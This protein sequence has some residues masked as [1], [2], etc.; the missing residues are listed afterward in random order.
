MMMG[1]QPELRKPTTDRLGQGELASGQASRAFHLLSRWAATPIPRATCGAIC[2]CAMAAGFIALFATAALAADADLIRHGEYLATAGDCVACHTA[3]GGKAHAGGLA[4]QTPIGEIYASNITPSKQYGIGNYTLAQFTDALRKGIRADGARLYPAMPYTSYA[5]ISDADIGAMYAYFMSAVTP[6]EQ[7]SAPTSLP[8]PFNIRL[9]MAG[10]NLLFL[11]SSRFTL[12]PKKT[13]EWNRGAYLVRGLAHCGVCHT[14]RNFLMAERSSRALGGTPLGTWYAPNITSDSNSGI[15]GWE[16]GE[17]ASYLKQGDAPGKA[18]ASGP[19]L[20]AID[21]SLRH[22]TDEDVR[23]IATYVKTVPAVSDPRETRAAFAWGSQ[24]HDLGSL[25]D[26][27]LPAEPDAM[28]GPQIYSAYCATCHNYGGQGS[29]S[30]GMPALFR[31]TALGRMDTSNLVMLI[32]EGIQRSEVQPGVVMPAFTKE[33]TDNQVSVLGNYLLQRFGNPSATVTADQVRQA[34]NGS[35]PSPLVL[36]A[37]AG[38][39]LVGVVI[40]ALLAFAMLRFRRKSVATL[41]I[42]DQGRNS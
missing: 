38:L 33:L 24:A 22:L 8:F 11:D 31:N 25:R 4:I 41:N 2:F 1:V 21:H 10:W 42:A 12:D 27:P 14:P 34:R 16:E 13:A 18:Q 32:L 7:P 17:L 37:R 26:V 28:T 39:V 6:V 23:A 15:G 40:V 29:L 9:M 30:P 35:S 19:M 20:E 5:L 3:P 36:I